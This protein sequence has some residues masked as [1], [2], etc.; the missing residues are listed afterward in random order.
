[1]PS[2]SRRSNNISGSGRRVAPPW[3]PFPRKIG[4][5]CPVLGLDGSTNEAGDMT[6]LRITLAAAAALVAGSLLTASAFAKSGATPV[7]PVSL[8][9]NLPSIGL[10]YNGLERVTSGPCLRAF[11]L[12]NADACTHG[13]DPAP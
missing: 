13:P 9:P 12:V 7:A 6:I 11:K 1:M 10:I 5:S 3:P 8:P 2:R 4:G